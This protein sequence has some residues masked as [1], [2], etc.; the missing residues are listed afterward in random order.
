MLNRH[1]P[2]EPRLSTEALN[3]PVY[4]FMAVT[5]GATS[6]GKNIRYRVAAAPGWQ[7]QFTLLWDK[8]VVSRQ[9][10]QAVAIDAGRLV[11]LANGRS[12]GYE[13]FEITQFDVSE[14]VRKPEKYRL[15]GRGL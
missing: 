10:M 5:R 11:G 13:C 3:E 14:D 12:I 8:T 4:V 9:E 2:K 6:R 15:V 1:L 7:S